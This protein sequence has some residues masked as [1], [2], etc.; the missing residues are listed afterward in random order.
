MSLSDTN[1]CSWSL[2]RALSLSMPVCSS[3]SFSISLASSSDQ[4]DDESAGMLLA[5]RCRSAKRLRNS[6]ASFIAVCPAFAARSHADF[7]SAVSLPSVEL[8]S[9]C[10]A[11]LA[12]AAN[13]VSSSILCFNSRFTIDCFLSAVLF[14]AFSMPFTASSNRTCSFASSSSAAGRISGLMRFAASLFVAKN[15]FAPPIAWCAE[16]A[17]FSSSV[18]VLLASSAGISSSP[19][20]KGASASARFFTAFSASTILASASFTITLTMTFSERSFKFLFETVRSTLACATLVC[21]FEISSLA[22]WRILPCKNLS[23]A[24]ACVCASVRAFSTALTS[25]DA[26]PFV[27]PSALSPLSSPTASSSSE[28]NISLIF[29]MEPSKSTTF[30]IASSA[31]RLAASL[32]STEIESFL[33]FITSD[34]A[35]VSLVCN[36]MKSAP[37]SGGASLPLASIW[38]SV[39]KRRA[40]S[41]A[42]FAAV[43]AFVVASAAV[44]MS[45]DESSAS[46]SSSTK[47]APASATSFANCST[48]ATCR[49]AS[50]VNA[51]RFRPAVFVFS[52]VSFFVFE[53]SNACD[54]FNFAVTSPLAE[55]LKRLASTNFVAMNIRAMETAVLAD[56]AAVS[57]AFTAVNVSSSGSSSTPMRNGPS[58]SAVLETNSCTVATLSVASFKRTWQ[59]TLSDASVCL[60]LTSCKRFCPLLRRS[61]S[62]AISAT[63]LSRVN[64]FLLMSRNRCVCR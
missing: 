4:V 5:S 12:S 29:L 18:R 53:S 34:C 55:G 43:S 33:Y 57:Q 24:F 21:N 10:V 8:S 19:F 60:V 49:S 62:F 14:F 64:F 46:L 3:P 40:S 35:V 42:R 27:S 36:L 11:S 9:A 16:R 54:S 28:A 17:A 58:A 44:L 56:V 52:V 20:K 51:L 2:M 13:F 15:V 50:R 48:S 30:A 1:L 61:S 38:R 47:T 7:I 26:L 32:D 23:T 22:P 6:A 41:M 25:T 45:A 31:A 59:V 37:A 63:A 39:M